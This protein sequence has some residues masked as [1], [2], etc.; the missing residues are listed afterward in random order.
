MKLLEEQFAKAFRALKMIEEDPKPKHPFELFGIEHG[1]GWY[2]L[3]LPIISEIGHYN[4]KNPGHEISIEQIK[5]K[6]GTLRF[7]TSG[8]P[9]YIEGMISMAENESKHICELCGARGELTEKNGWYMTLCEHHKKAR[10][11][12]NG[13]ISESKLYRKAMKI[14]NNSSWLR[15]NYDNF[16]F[17]ILND[18]LLMAKTKIDGKLYVIKLERE[19]ARTVFYIKK[20]G[21]YEKLDIY[22]QWAKDE[23]NSSQKKHWYVIKNDKKMPNGLDKKEREWQEKRVVDLIFYT[24]KCDLEDEILQESS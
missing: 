13:Y 17:K 12:E 3:I 16:E 11:E 14:Y 2:G 5:E 6:F 1:Y 15:G 19:K 21:K 20:G 23:D 24:I 9:D 18:N 8:S 4:E 22:V 7:Y 10:E